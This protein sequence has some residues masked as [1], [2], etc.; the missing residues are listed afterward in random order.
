MKRSLMLLIVVAI[1]FGIEVAGAL[2]TL[3]G[4]LEGGTELDVDL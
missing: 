3:R 2:S 4:A 1:T